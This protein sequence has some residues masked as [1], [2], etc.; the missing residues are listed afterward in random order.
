M[1]IVADENIIFAKEAFSAF[2]EVKTLP[3]RT[4]TRESLKKIDVLLVRSVTRVDASLLAGTPVQFVGTATIGVDHLD[5]EYL[6]RNGIAFTNAAGCNANAVAEYI[7]TAILHVAACKNISLEKSSLGIVG[8][9]NIGKR[10]DQLARAL[11]MK[12]LLNDPPLQRKTGDAVFRDLDALMQADFVTLHVPLIKEGMGKTVHLF[13]DARLK[14]L[15]KTIALINTSRGP[16]IDN[17]ALLSWK[18]GAPEA[19]LILDVWE[20]EPEISPALLEQTFVATPHIAGYTFEGK[21]NGARML[22]KALEK[23]FAT[24]SGWAPLPARQ[25]CKIFPAANCNKLETF[26]SEI[27]GKANPILKDN[28]QLKSGIT[29][30]GGISG[31]F[32]TLRKNY[33]LRREFENFEVRLSKTQRKF[34]HVLRALGF[35]TPV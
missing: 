24:Q 29:K 14:K 4:I 34:A 3:G 30:G 9:G 13:D 35:K 10:V 16:V 15:S 19:T 17:Q 28:Y 33:A 18:K 23:H 25:S 20:N 32:E 12:T 21:V 2:G 6:I 22:V 5:Q 27:T 7:I 8:V 11:G 1:R 31:H 26:L